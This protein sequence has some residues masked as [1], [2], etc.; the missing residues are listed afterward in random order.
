MNAFPSQV[1]ESDQ[2]GKISHFSIGG[3]DLR[4]YFAA[5]AMQ[6]LVTEGKCSGINEITN[7]SYG[8]ADSMMESRQ[9]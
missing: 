5:T 1:W 7:L 6:G 9:K 3:M 2:N 8:I 4:D